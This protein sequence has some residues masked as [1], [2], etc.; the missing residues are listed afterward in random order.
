[1]QMGKDGFG[2]QLKGIQYTSSWLGVTESLRY[3][4]NDAD[5][6]L[7]NKRYSLLLGIEAHPWR[8]LLISPF[9]TA[10]AGWER[11]TREEPLPA[12]DS[13]MGEAAAGLEMSLGRFASLAAQWTEDYYADLNE[14]MFVEQKKAGDAT[15]NYRRHALAE[16]FFNLRWAY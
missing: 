4:G 9:F 14:P 2:A 1:M 13:Y 6:R 3:F 12:I 10:Q 5:D 11:F 16:V 7:Y 15:K 8:Q